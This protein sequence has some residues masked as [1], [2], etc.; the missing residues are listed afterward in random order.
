MKAV[1]YP[2]LRGTRSDSGQPGTQC[3]ST[4]VRVSKYVI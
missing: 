4:S 1:A 3:G 2:R